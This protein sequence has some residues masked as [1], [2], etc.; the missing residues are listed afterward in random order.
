MSY[1][2]FNRTLGRFSMCTFKGLKQFVRDSFHSTLRFLIWRDQRNHIVHGKE[3][4]LVGFP[5]NM[6]DP[7]RTCGIMR[8][9]Y[10]VDFSIH[11]LPPSFSSREGISG[12]IFTFE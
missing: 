2:V 1:Q 5:L 11:S 4:G 10:A 3:F 9:G 6:V 12:E 7:G 8:F